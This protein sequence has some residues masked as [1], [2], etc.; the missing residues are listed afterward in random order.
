MKKSSQDN[1]SE[2][3]IIESKQTPRLAWFDNYQ[4]QQDIDIWQ[5]LSPDSD[6]EDW[7]YNQ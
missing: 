6:I 3:I 1:N 2:L 4:E 7:E 5:T